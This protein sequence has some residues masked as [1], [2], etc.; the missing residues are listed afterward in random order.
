MQQGVLR[1]VSEV[2]AIAKTGK[3]DELEQLSNS[4][5]TLEKAFVKAFYSQ[6]ALIADD[7]QPVR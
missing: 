7:F 4:H 6:H 5:H 1:L 3:T 2:N